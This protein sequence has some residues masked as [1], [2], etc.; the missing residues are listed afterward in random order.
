MKV[1]EIGLQ[2]LKIIKLDL[3]KDNRGFF[4]EKFNEKTLKENDIEMKCIQVNHSFSIANVIRGLHFQINPAQKKLV[5]VTTG[6]ILDVAV[7]IRKNSKTFGKH[8]TI[9]IESPDTLLFIP[10]GFA[11]GFSVLSKEGANLLYAVEGAFNKAGDGGIAYN[12]PDLKIDW[13]VKNPIV[14]EKDLKLQNFNNYIN[15]TLF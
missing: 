13:K 5:G 11:H 15:N 10:E 9:Q 3:Y 14:S 8:F 1:I 12:D 2:D 6:T 4:V 7:D